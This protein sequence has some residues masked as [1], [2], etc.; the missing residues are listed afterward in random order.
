MI[1]VSLM[2]TC[3]SELVEWH[4]RGMMCGACKD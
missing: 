3:C 1:V 2:K 4:W